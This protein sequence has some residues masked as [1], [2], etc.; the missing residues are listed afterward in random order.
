MDLGEDQFQDG[1]CSVDGASDEEDNDEAQ[2]PTEPGTNF[3]RV[4]SSINAL[5][6]RVSPSVEFCARNTL[7]QLL[8]AAGQAAYLCQWEIQQKVCNYI[9]HLQRGGGLKGLVYVEHQS[10]D[11]TPLKLRVTD[12]CSQSEHPQISKVFVSQSSWSCLVED[13]M[14]DAESPSRFLWIRGGRMPQLRCAASATAEAIAAVMD[15]GWPSGSGLRLNTDGF[16]MHTRLTECD[17]FS[18]NLRAERLMH[19]RAVQEHPQRQHLLLVGLC[20]AH[21]LHASALRGF[22]LC[23]LTVQGLTRVLLCLQ[24]PGIYAEFK[25]RL[26]SCVALSTQR[27]TDPQPL[28]SQAEQFKNNVCAYFFPSTSS[29]SSKCK[30]AVRSLTQVL[31]GDWRV[32]GR[33][34]HHCSS[35]QC[36][37]ALSDTKKKL[38]ALIRRVLRSLR[39]RI[40]NKS[41]WLSWSECM[42][43]VGM[44][45]GMH[46]M[47]PHLLPG[48]LEKQGAEGPPCE[49]AADLPADVAPENIVAVEAG[50]E[51][52]DQDDVPARMRA[53]QAKHRRLAL[54]WLAE[55]EEAF[56]HLYILR[57]TLQ[58]QVLAMRQLVNTCTS[59]FEVQQMSAM[60]VGDEDRP[61]HRAT[62]LTRGTL[63]AEFPRKALEQLNQRTVWSH[64]PSNEAYAGQVFQQALRPCAVVFELIQRRWQHWPH[65]VF[66]LLDPEAKVR[67]AEALVGTSACCLDEFTL[68]FR[69]QFRSVPLLPGQRCQQVLSVLATEM[70]TT[71]WTTECLLA[72]HA[73]RAHARVHT[74]RAHIQD[75]ACLHASGTVPQWQQEILKAKEEAR[76]EQDPDHQSRCSSPAHPPQNLPADPRFQNQIGMTSWG[77]KTTPLEADMCW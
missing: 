30:A 55:P 53:E 31:N 71:T 19:L 40:L 77:L 15:S 51:A 8:Q 12:P 17:E 54:D 62:A 69:A 25:T 33:F 61:L 39:P 35:S 23:P 60:V 14:V 64:L 70:M 65:R 13:Q 38:E 37:E 58:P 67:T 1:A 42:S 56:A 73:R 27:I 21:K 6:K 3:E 4:L 11:E 34:V 26:L 32:R 72:R 57:V 24:Q 66:A 22:S 43:W 28:S 52:H 68:Q 46:G 48:I 5:T 7:Q 44:F 59:Q 75:L 16:E 63:C 9:H 2:R 10:Y 49:H 47:L 20:T 45:M 50:A 41:N 18:A 74:H 29:S 76:T 36:C